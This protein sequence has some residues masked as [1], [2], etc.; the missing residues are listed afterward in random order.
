MIYYTLTNYVKL[1]YDK[2]NYTL[3]RSLMSPKYLV[4]SKICSMQKTPR[5]GKI[6]G[7][8]VCMYVYIYIYI[9]TYI[10]TYTYAIYDIHARRPLRQAWWAPEGQAFCL[11]SFPCA[12]G[13]GSALQAPTHI[14]TC[15]III[16]MI[17][18]IIIIMMIVII[19][20]III[21]LLLLLLLYL[22]LIVVIIYIYIYILII[23]GGRLPDACR[24]L[25]SQAY[26]RAGSR[27]TR[28]R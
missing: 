9:Y 14:I 4:N 16:M 6:I 22:L 12:G 27:L 5:G 25:R 11:R 23:M 2:L 18:I 20:I 8:Y 3:L 7:P 24:E 1:Y 28:A 13:F 17:I 26:S 19:I 10:H 21:I 15:I